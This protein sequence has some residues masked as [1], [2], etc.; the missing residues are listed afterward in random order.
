MSFIPS[1]S[2]SAFSAAGISHI[3]PAEIVGVPKLSMQ[4]ISGVAAA[5]FTAELVNNF[6]AVSGGGCE[7][8]T[9]DILT[10]L[11][12]A[13]HSGFSK[14]CL[15]LIPSTSFV[16]LTSDGL[17]KLSVTV[18]PALDKSDVEHISTAASGLT[19]EQVRLLFSLL[20]F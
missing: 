3:V 5:G 8:V 10:G 15:A 9:A 19:A 12:S 20:L 2:F 7:G 6:G 1:A 11:P 13:S 17:A 16:G 18:I 4:Q 14:P